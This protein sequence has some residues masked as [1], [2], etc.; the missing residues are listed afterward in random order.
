MAIPVFAIGAGDALKDD[1]YK[2]ALEEL[3]EH[4]GGKAFFLKE[5]E[6][7]QRAFSEISLSLK[8]SYRAGYYPGRPP[9][10][11][12]H[13]ITVTLRFKKGQVIARHGYYAK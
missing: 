12:W 6:E 11:K 2:K 5:L 4:T 1:R 7:M 9:D 10:G 3:A 8:S 13:K